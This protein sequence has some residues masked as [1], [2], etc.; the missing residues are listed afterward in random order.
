MDFSGLTAYRGFAPYGPLSVLAG[1]A[2]V[3][4]S[5][6]GAEITTVAAAESK[7]PARA[8]AAMTTTLTLRVVLFYVLSIFLVIV[9]VNWTTI[10]PGIR[11]L[12]RR[13]PR[14]AFPAW[15]WV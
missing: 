1:V 5:L 3:I 6:T 11:P 2:T 4:F 8:I 7:E 10:K 15:L 13:W 14:S 12:S 9:A